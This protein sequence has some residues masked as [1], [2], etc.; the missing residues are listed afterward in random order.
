MADDTKTV[1]QPEIDG[2]K[3]YL[4]VV[5]GRQ[6]AV[7]KDE[8]TYDEVVE[9]A[10]GELPSGPNVE[11]VVSYRESAGRPAEGFLVPGGKV[12]VGDGTVIL[13]STTDKS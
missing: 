9:L 1:S 12:K 2:H 13:V 10:L 4:I 8:L 11:V 6:Q 5:N 7:D 3:T